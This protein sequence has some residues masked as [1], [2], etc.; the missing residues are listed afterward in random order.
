MQL[1]IIGNEET[2][3][4]MYIEDIK[5]VKQDDLAGKEIRSLFITDKTA[6]VANIEA[7]LS[8]LS[9]LE[10]LSL[11]MPIDKVPTGL[12]RLKLKKLVINNINTELELA[13]DELPQSLET[14][15]ISV[16][17]LSSL[18]SGT[19]KCSRVSVNADVLGDQNF[20]IGQSHQD[21]SYDL[22]INNLTEL[23]LVAAKYISVRSK[24]LTGI[25]QQFVAINKDVTTILRLDSPLLE[26]IDNN[27]E[28]FNKLQELSF[29]TEGKI[30]NNDMSFINAE[31]SNLNIKTGTLAD[32]DISR[33]TN[34][35]SIT[36]EGIT[37]RNI[38]LN[39][40]KLRSLRI[41][42]S[43]IDS[44]RG[45][46]TPH[47]TNLRINDSLSHF[48]EEIMSFV[49][50]KTIVMTS[51]QIESVPSD[52]SS[53]PD[54]VDLI[55]H[56]NNILFDNFSFL[57]EL[58]KLKNLTVAKN[59]ITNYYV[60]LVNKMLP[61]SDHDIGD[62]LDV[63][64]SRVSN[65]LR[66]GAALH[67]SKI[68]EETKKKLF[69]N[70]IKE[71]SF[72][73]FLHS[74]IENLII[75]GKINFPLL[76][77]ELT[78]VL[79]EISKQKP[80]FDSIE[81]AKVF[82]DGK[83][84]MTQNELSEKL[85][86][87][88]ATLVK[89][90]SDSV[91]HVILGTKPKNINSFG[92]DILY[93]TEMDIAEIGESEKFINVQLEQGN[94]GMLDK[95]ISF[96]QNPDATNTRLG[97]NMLNSGG[98]DPAFFPAL[99]AIAKAHIDSNTRK[100]AKKLLELHGPKEW[101]P[102]LADKLLFKSMNGRVK[103]QAI[104]NKLQSLAADIGLDL[105]CELCLALYGRFQKGL[106]FM[107]L[108]SNIS[109]MHRNRM[110]NLLCSGDKFELDRGLGFKNW[111]GVPVDQIEANTYKIK[112]PL[113]S[114]VNAYRKVER[115]GLHN[116][117]I[118]TV[119][120]DLQEFKDVVVVDLSCNNIAKLPAFFAKLDWIEELDLSLNVFTEFPKVLFKMKGLK[121]LNLSNNRIHGFGFKLSE[122]VVPDDF[123]EAK[124]NCLVIV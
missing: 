83:A 119:S 69:D 37:S 16:K 8:Q 112:F 77:K 1:I 81:G 67:R 33:F 45:M 12:N 64:P 2:A 123:R 63:L 52:W 121:K 85:T 124:P 78:K 118:T 24:K 34:A 61:F 88:N 62:L 98:V 76:Q 57:L 82:V 49:K 70:Y 114:G 93:V 122:I 42:K 58:K 21:L 26:N 50:L 3:R 32:V 43:K 91:T 28:S 68:D 54:L 117:K 65:I 7:V 120:K 99:L 79:G 97:L 86:R 30:S 111:K 48:P 80:G 116:T 27:G 59:R 10:S 75:A 40:T 90:W 23:P 17:Y 72:A 94:I 15:A 108:Q 22:Y 113:H 66:L 53:L 71:P 106:R 109:V 13:E 107:V 11:L 6:S 19:W 51:N 73:S 18:P 103:E 87:V 20:E 95:V 38:Q 36:L 105:T 96:L 14:I 39:S 31:I 74:S 9:G 100:H 41:S 56:N 44:L 5:N 104:N 46:N 60:F 25:Q 84:K 110:Y 102:L 29:G 89:R 101:E 35:E 47:I 92:P 55:L 115:L 4:G